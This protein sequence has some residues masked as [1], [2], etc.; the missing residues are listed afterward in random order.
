M[1]NYR[2]A[3]IAGA[4]YFFTVVAYR[5]QRILCDDAVR[6]ALRTA[7]AATRA[8]RPFDILAWVLLPDHLHCIWTL[9]DGD[10]DFATR[11]SMI[12]RRVSLA[13]RI[14]HRQTE[15]LT[16]SKRKHRESTLWQRR[17]W[18]HQIKDEADLARHVDYI[19]Y[20]PVRHGLVARPADWPYSTLHRD[21]A[22]GI[23]P[24][25]WG[26]DIQE[27]ELSTAGE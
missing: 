14:S 26:E 4:T 25:H 2:R 22:R 12:K 3:S 20:N 11:W 27:R 24:L 7:I 16:A 18:E 8:D 19:H 10:A 6:F 21:I 13:C 1:P 17:Y 5:R 23:Y 9:P 15:L